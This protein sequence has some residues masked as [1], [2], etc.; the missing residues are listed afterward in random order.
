MSGKL[1]NFYRVTDTVVSRLQAYIS[2]KADYIVPG[3]FHLYHGPISQ[4]SLYCQDASQDWTRTGVC[5]DSQMVLGNEAYFYYSPGRMTV[6]PVAIE[7]TGP[8]AAHS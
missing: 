8:Q 4:A 5:V 6:F 1:H 2:L 7:I 3:D